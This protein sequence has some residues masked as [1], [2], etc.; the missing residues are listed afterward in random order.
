MADLKALVP[1]VDVGL[2][3][4]ERARTNFD[5]PEALDEAL[6]A[7]LAESIDAALSSFDPESVHLLG[8]FSLLDTMLATPMQ[9][10]VTFLPIENKL[11][12][13]LRRTPNNESLPLVQL[14]QCVEE[15]RWGDA[16]GM[17]RR[18]NIAVALIHEPKILLCDEPTVGV[19]RDGEEAIAVAVGLLVVG[20]QVQW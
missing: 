12:E 18:L 14:A 1:P 17:M 3:L 20:H 11:K 4:E 13:A 6:L 8:L 9:E 5:A 16:D 7:D 2:P 10:I 19:D 15:N